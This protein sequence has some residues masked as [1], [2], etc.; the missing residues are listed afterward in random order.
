M[1]LILVLFGCGGDQPQVNVES[2]GSLLV[3]GIALPLGRA[4]AS[5]INTPNPVHWAGVPMPAV[6]KVNIFAEHDIPSS[7]VGEATG[8]PA[9]S[10]MIGAGPQGDFYNGRWVIPDGL[11]LIAQGIK[12]YPTLEALPSCRVRITGNPLLENDINYEIEF[13]FTKG[14]TEYESSCNG[15]VTVFTSTEYDQENLPTYPPQAPPDS[16]CFH[17]AGDTLFPV[18]F[19]TVEDRTEKV[20]IFS[21]FA[22]LEPYDITSGDPRKSGQS[23]LVFRLPERMAH[24]QPVQTDAMAIVY[25]DSDSLLAY[26]SPVFGYVEASKKGGT[27]EG[28]LNFQNNG[29]SGATGF[30]GGGAFTALIK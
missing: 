9:L 21:V 16:F 6:L 13:C 27:L 11:E 4:R 3:D 29:S 30:H 18:Q 19:I 12:N 17:L 28:V 22:F 25:T 24:G 15:L 10:F 5:L 7:A 1:L 23:H 8:Q 2:E 26:A 14:D 20:D